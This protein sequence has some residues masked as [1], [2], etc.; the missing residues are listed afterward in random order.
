L[1]A[2]AAAG[3][4]LALHRWPPPARSWLVRSAAASSLAVRT[5]ATVALIKTT[6]HREGVLRAVQLAPLPSLRD[7]TV[8]IKPNLNSSDPFPG[9]THLE[10]LRVLLEICR[11]GGAREIIVADRSGMGDTMRVIRE[12]GVD[13]L[14][15]TVGARVLALEDLPP[16][17][18][19]VRSLPGSNWQRGLLFPRMFE[20]ADVII[21]TCCLK[22]HRFGGQFTLS[23]K[24]SVGM[25]A[26]R[27][28]DGY[29]YMRELHSSSLQRILIAELNMLYKPG[30]I[31]LDGLEAFVEGG[32]DTG[33]LARPGVMLAGTDRV[34]IDAAGVALLRMH[35]VTGPVAQGPI[36]AQEQI[37]RA[38]QLG[39]GVASPDDILFVTDSPEGRGVID[40]VR[41]ALSRA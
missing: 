36:F 15:R 9:S 12:K 8:V 28:P 13:T 1:K 18:F 27:G 20:R 17:E 33:T 16:S 31:V 39:I 37:K 25:V 34:A 38:V 19:V 22:T 10:T 7:R 6:S 14:A 41:A 26:R 35:G 3:G 29:D 32:P 24:N 30:L 5:R 4:A 11:D 2:L 23:L 21:S 40:A